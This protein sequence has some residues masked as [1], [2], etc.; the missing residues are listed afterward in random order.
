MTVKHIKNTTK[1]INLTRIVKPHQSMTS[2]LKGYKIS[3]GMMEK[4]NKNYFSELDR[5][6]ILSILNIQYKN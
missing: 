5:D 3:D 6:T 2:H 1:K 4:L